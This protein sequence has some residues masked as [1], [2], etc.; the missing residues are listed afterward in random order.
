MH[1]LLSIAVMECLGR[2]TSS[3]QSVD[4][5]FPLTLMII[6]FATISDSGL[7][8]Y[9]HSSVHPVHPEAE[10]IMQA[11]V[12][13][14]FHSMRCSLI[15]DWWHNSSE[16]FCSSKWAR[17]LQI[18]RINSLLCLTAGLK[19][20][21]IL[22][23]TVLTEVPCFLSA[24]SWPSGVTASIFATGTWFKCRDSERHALLPSLQLPVWNSSGWRMVL[25]YQ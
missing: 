11:H 1:S 6:T 14:C 4:L 3:I 23:Y 22:N 16:I 10:K 8:I 19:T 25:V 24:L 15:T 17:C 5:V 13:S 12:D 7:Y 18:D 21:P 20:T 2:E 9:C